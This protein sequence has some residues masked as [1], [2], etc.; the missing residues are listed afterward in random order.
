MFNFDEFNFFLWWKI[1]KLNAGDAITIFI[2]FCPFFQGFVEANEEME[3]FV[4]II[5]GSPEPFHKSLRLQVAHF[6]PHSIDVRGQGVFPRLVLDLPRQYTPEEQQVFEEAKA[7][8]IMR[9]EAKNADQNRIS[10]LNITN[11][12]A[13]DD[14]KLKSV[15]QQKTLFSMNTFLQWK[16]SFGNWV[17]SIQTL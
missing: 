2:R 7:I 1:L 6:E 14:K 3:L 16:M 13:G 17:C 11:A 10:F 9:H 5:P 8:L 15:N 4:N 12:N